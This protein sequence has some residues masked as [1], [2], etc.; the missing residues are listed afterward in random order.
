MLYGTSD[1]EPQTDIVLAHLAQELYN[2]HLL[3]L[4]IQ[5]LQKIDFEVRQIFYTIY[6]YIRIFILGVLHGMC[7]KMCFIITSFIVMTIRG[8]K[9]L[10]R[11]LI[12]S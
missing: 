9:M 10:L 4:L 8:R 1:Q 7:D 2:S 6:T 12:T 11:F 5:N 3:L